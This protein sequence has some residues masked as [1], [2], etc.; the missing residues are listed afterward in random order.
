MSLKC[1]NTVGFERNTGSNSENLES[2]DTGDNGFFFHL[3]AV[4]N[5][6]MGP[7]GLEVEVAS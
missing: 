4:D 1:C 7:N 5:E 6:K 2:H 3:V